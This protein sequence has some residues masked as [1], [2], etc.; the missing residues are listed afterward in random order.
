[1]ESPATM[2]GVDDQSSLKK[3]I[4]PDTEFLK[5]TSFISKRP[6]FLNI[7]SRKKLCLQYEVSNI[8]LTK[9]SYKRVFM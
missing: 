3:E 1:M 5:V 9:K 4:L 8:I 6:N 2:F 7:L